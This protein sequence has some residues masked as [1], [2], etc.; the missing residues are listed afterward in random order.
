M[1]KIIIAGDFVPKYRVLDLLKQENY[2]SVLAEVKPV[3][4][5]A[6]YSIVNLEAPIMDGALTPIVKNG[7]NLN[8][9]VNTL[10]AIKYAGFKCV[11][12]ANNHFYDQGEQGA[13]MTMNECKVRGIDFVGAGM[14]LLEASR[15]IYK[16]INGTTY[17]FINC[18]EHE[19]SIATEAT[20][21]SNP[22]S[23]IR[24][25]YAIVEAKKKAKF[26]IV[27]VHGGVEFYQYPTLRMV[28][29]YR[30]FVDVGADVV[31]NHHQHCFSGFEVYKGKPIFYG[32][33]NFCFD[34]N[35]SKYDCWNEGYM[36]NLCFEGENIDYEVLPYIQCCETPAVLLLKEKKEFCLRLADINKTILSSMKLETKWKERCKK[37]DVKN[38]EWLF[39]PYSNSFLKKIYFRGFLPTMINKHT[40]MELRD[41][42]LCESHYERLKR[43][44]LSRL[45]N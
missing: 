6:D 1:D 28:E 39:S 8:A 21:G 13:L 45:E 16:D 44:V 33:G 26:V 23:P 15:T 37:K 10:D 24:Q 12:L 43:F 14:N 32:L 41:F 42:L 19:Y 2:A 17:A 7:P 30:F 36:V 35:V 9:P 40:W 3:V 29:W 18:C 20:A 38:I 22:I 34:R 4:E 5:K 25:Y 11:S 27:I 31:V